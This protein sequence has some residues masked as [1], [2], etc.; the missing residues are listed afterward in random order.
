MNQGAAIANFGNAHLYRLTLTENTGYGAYANSAYFDDTQ[1]GCISYL[2]NCTVTNN[3]DDEANGIDLYDDNGGS[4][5]TLINSIVA[6]NKGGGVDLVQ[7][8]GSAFLNGNN[9]IGTSDSLLFNEITDMLGLDP[10]LDELTNV[11]GT[12]YYHPLKVNSPAIN[13]IANDSDNA[14]NAAG[15]NGDPKKNRHLR[16]WGSRI[17]SRYLQHYCLI[18]LG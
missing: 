4:T 2:T 9:I 17:G 13:A 12:V 14:E 1:I 7:Y 16:Y 15:K 18:H 6:G 3:Y 10:L 8:N 5:L 11:S